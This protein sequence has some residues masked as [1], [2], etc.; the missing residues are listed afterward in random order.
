MDV[1]E[2]LGDQRAEA[3]EPDPD[4]AMEEFITWYS[5]KYGDVPD[6]DAAEGLAEEWL[7]IML[8]G[9]E[10]LVSPRRIA[11]FRDALT[12]MWLDEEEVAGALALLPDWVRWNGE[13]AGMAP[14]LVDEAVSAAKG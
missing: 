3:P 5:A 14:Q 12:G 9:S 10:Y 7:G 11:A 4:V 1:I 8:R 6:G 13:Q 2:K